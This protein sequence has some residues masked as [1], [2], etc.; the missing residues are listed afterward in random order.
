L[1][2]C[3]HH[4][5]SVRADDVVIRIEIATRTCGGIMGMGEQVGDRLGMRMLLANLAVHPEGV[6]INPRS[7][8]AGADD[9][10]GANRDAEKACCGCRRAANI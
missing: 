5:A 3:T 10:G 9:R 7:D 2:I 6:P 8:R 1:P 4:D